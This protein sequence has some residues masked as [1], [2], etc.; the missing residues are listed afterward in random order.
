MVERSKEVPVEFCLPGPRRTI[1]VAKTS[2]KVHTYR[3]C[4]AISQAEVE[5]LDVPMTL[6]R[7]M[8]LCEKCNPSSGVQRRKARHNV[9]IHGSVRSRMSPPT[10]SGYSDNEE[11]TSHSVSTMSESIAFTGQPRGF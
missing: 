3:V 6:L 1:Y 11:A 10:P 9:P 8:P 5:E 4:G 2:Q 7:M